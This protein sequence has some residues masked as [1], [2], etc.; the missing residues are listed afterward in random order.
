MVTEKNNFCGNA[1]HSFAKSKVISKCKNDKPCLKLIRKSVSPPPLLSRPAPATYFH[2]FFQLFR[3]PLPLR[4]GN[5][6]L[7]PPLKKRGEA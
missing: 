2:P 1:S 7:L 5:Q 4:G 6:N 3:F